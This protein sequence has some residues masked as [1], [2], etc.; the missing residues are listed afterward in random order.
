MNADANQP[1]PEWL[2]LHILNKKLAH[3]SR[4][5]LMDCH[6]NAVAAGGWEKRGVG[7]VKEMEE[8]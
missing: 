6:A 3:S 7:I 5:P 4:L 1:I 2:P 8:V